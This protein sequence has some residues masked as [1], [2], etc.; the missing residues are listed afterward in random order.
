MRCRF[1]GVKTTI[2]GWRPSLASREIVLD[3]LPPG[4]EF[5]AARSVQLIEDPVKGG[6]DVRR[7]PE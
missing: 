2:I 5:A 1:D 3:F 6:E 7:E 4:G